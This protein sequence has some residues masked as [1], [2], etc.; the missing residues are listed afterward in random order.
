MYINS[1][2]QLIHNDAKETAVDG[3]YCISNL[4]KQEFLF[5]S[6]ELPF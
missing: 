6:T 2:G 1:Q 3:I 5:F 4:I